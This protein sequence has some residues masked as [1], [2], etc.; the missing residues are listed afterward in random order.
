MPLP[1]GLL[2]ILVCP[3][4]H[5]TLAEEGEQLVCATCGLRYPVRDG[6]PIM[7]PEEATRAEDHDG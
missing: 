3:V 2:D 7:L 5:G 6:V 4:D 1:E